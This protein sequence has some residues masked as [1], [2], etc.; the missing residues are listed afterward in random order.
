MRLGI[1]SV[2]VTWLTTLVRTSC[3]CDTPQ[4]TAGKQHWLAG[5]TTAPP[6]SQR[7]AAAE[8]SPRAFLLREFGGPP[9]ATL[10]SHWEMGNAQ[11]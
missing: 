8:D 5:R 2:G 1:I 11:N 7:Q 4:M 9:L 10:A 3:Q 6:P